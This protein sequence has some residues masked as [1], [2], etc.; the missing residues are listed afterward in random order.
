M[1]WRKTALWCAG[2]LAILVI[3]CMAA[4]EVLVDP[5]RLKQAAHARVKAATGRELQV[6][7]IALSLLPVPSILATQVALANPTWARERNLVAIEVVRAD[8]ELLPLL[9]GRMRVKALSLDG[10]HLALEE[11]DDGAVSWSFKRDEATAKG[12]A[13]DADSPMVFIPELRI[14]K[15]SIL[16]LDK[17]EP[18]EPWQVEEA[19]FLSDAGLRNVTLEAKISR[20]KQP[21]SIKAQLAV[22]SHAGTEGAVS[23]G[24]L[25]LAWNETRATVS[26]RFPLERRLEGH[27]LE[28]EAKSK[29]L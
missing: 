24:K 27:A 19:A 26:G 4:L 29:S 8:L 20:H 9:E 23:E 21:L 16:H 17:R 10:V 6:G 5:E 13:S 1:N 11:A 25:T 18:A 28:A 14:R 7:G 22:L 12:P 15:A 2:I 3:A